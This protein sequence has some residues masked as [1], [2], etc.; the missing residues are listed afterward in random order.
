M[1]VG[2]FAQEGL[3]PLDPAQSLLEY[4]STEVAE[5]ERERNAPTAD[6]APIAV[7][8]PWGEEEEE[9]TAPR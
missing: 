3:G 2:Y 6:G 1:R 9:T 7:A 4:V 5:A 8:K